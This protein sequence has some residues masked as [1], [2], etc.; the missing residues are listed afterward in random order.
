MIFCSLYY[1]MVYL[2]AW[3]YVHY[4]LFLAAVPTSPAWICCILLP[5]KAAMNIPTQ[6]LLGIFRRVSLRWLPRNKMSEWQ[7]VPGFNF[8]KYCLVLPEWLCE[9]TCPQWYLGSPNSSHCHQ[10]LRILTFLICGVCKSGI[11]LF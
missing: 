1:F 4:M 7:G 3:L 6:L 2:S 10:H 8:A 5:V 9:F 11:S